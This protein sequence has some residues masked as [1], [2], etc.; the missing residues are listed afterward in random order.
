M[1]NPW[2]STGGQAKSRPGLAEPDLQIYG[3]ITPHR[4]HARY[5]ASTPGISFFTVLQR[6]KSAG[7]LTLRSADP[8]TQPALDPDYLS[9]TDGSDLATLVDGVRLSRRIA[10]QKALS[11]LDLKEI[12]P[13]AEA[14][15]N[16][17][18]ALFVR[19]HCQS[20]YHPTST[21]RMGTDPLAVVDPRSLKVRG[22]EGLRVIDA[23]VFPDVVASNICATVFMVAERGADFIINQAA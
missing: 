3:V 9:D 16:S 14:T 6:P 1:A 12:T 8:L 5:F 20:I 23:S 22:I 2:S 7:R 19:R 11:H 10:T 17:E 4:D 21:C 13:S 18:I 15:T